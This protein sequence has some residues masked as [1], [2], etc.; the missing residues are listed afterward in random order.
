MAC[1]IAIT[2][3]L[4]GMTVRI[5]AETSQWM[6][7]ILWLWEVIIVLWIFFIIIYAYQSETVNSLVKLEDKYRLILWFTYLF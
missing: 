1:Q 6:M 2:E 7:L 3:D 4:D 5:K